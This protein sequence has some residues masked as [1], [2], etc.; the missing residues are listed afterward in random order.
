[1][2]IL[3]SNAISLGENGCI[4]AST[5]MDKEIR[6]GTQIEDYFVP[7]L[8]I[9][10]F[11]SFQ[12]ENDKK[13]YQTV[14]EEKEEYLAGNGP[15]CIK[16]RVPEEACKTITVD[17]STTR[18]KSIENCKISANHTKTKHHQSICP[19][20]K[21]FPL[22][23]LLVLLLIPTIVVVA[24]KLLRHTLNEGIVLLLQSTLSNSIFEGHNIF[25]EL[26]KV[27]DYGMSL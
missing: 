22:F 1:M 4:D 7:S 12:I 23:I 8:F 2:F 3:L 26:E 6:N 19:V 20:N 11:H 17:I 14:I 13:M 9:E 24:L 27:S 18:S 21:I 10:D 15:S 5:R 16:N 25:I